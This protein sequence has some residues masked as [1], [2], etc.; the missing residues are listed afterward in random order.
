MSIT[1]G[2]NAQAA[3]TPQVNT[4]YQ[5]ACS[6]EYQNNLP[7]AIE[8]LKQAIALA[9][10]DSML[11]TKLAGIYSDLGEYDLALQAY[12]KVLELKPDDAFVYI[13]VGSIYETQGKYQEALAAYNKSIQRI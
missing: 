7:D 8:K 11:Y 3:M 9:G 1:T 12:S 13:S 2:I 4:L 5:Q 6:A 10:N